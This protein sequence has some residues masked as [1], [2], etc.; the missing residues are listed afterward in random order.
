MRIVLVVIGSLL[1]AILAT[2]YALENPGYVLIARPPWSIE[3]SLTVFAALWLVGTALLYA[4]IYVIVRLVRIPHDVGRWRQRRLVRQARQALHQ[5]LIKLAEGDW[6]EAEAELVTSMRGADEPALSYLGA[7]FANQAQGN[8]EKRD[9]YLAAAHHAAPQ[10]HLAIGMTQANLQYLAKQSEQALA[11][12]TELRAAAPRHKH[13]LKLLAQLYLELRD[14]TNLAEIV[15]ELRAQ[16]VMT[17]KE[18]DALEFRAQRELLVLTL[19]SG[20][21]DVLQ[22]A[23]NAVPK[24]LRRQPA[25]IAI[26]ARQLIRQNE[27]QAAEALLRQT[28]DQEWDDPLIEL[29]GQ[30]RGESATEQLETAESWLASYPDHPKLLLTLGRLAAVAKQDSKARGYFE[31]CIAVRGP[32]EA[33]RE[34]GMLLERLGENDKA[35]TCYRRGVEAYADNQQLSA[36]RPAP[37]LMPL[38][39]VR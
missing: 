5:G 38:R 7:A 32:I 36:G 39:V 3:M 24:H 22:R 4:A 18:I 20:S 17:P 28:L 10:R 26:Y 16:S 8:I 12:L 35:L 2:L 9:E 14:W 13:V 27:M 30:A 15:P 31:R 33:Y 21:L 11:T 23:W 19:P 25:L 34:L 1:A 6:V 29:Y 37:G